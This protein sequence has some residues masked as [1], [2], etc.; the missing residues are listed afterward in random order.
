MA[1]SKDQFVDRASDVMYIVYLI[2]RTAKVVAISQRSKRSKPTKPKSRLIGCAADVEWTRGIVNKVSRT[3]TEARA[4]PLWSK[5]DP[6]RKRGLAEDAEL[7]NLQREE[8]TGW[9]KRTGRRRTGSG[10]PDWGE[11]AAEGSS[12]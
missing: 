5:K 11:E 4:T 2:S 8:G 12:C 3:L 7:I 6:K 1:T 9:E 10:R